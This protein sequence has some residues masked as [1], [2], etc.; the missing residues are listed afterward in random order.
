MIE[1]IDAHNRP[2]RP[3]SRASSTLLLPWPAVLLAASPSVDMVHLRDRAPVVSPQFSTCLR[4]APRPSQSGRRDH[5]VGSITAAP[6]MSLLPKAFGH[7]A[8]TFGGDCGV[9]VYNEA[10][11][12]SMAGHS[13]AWEASFQSP[14]APC[15]VAA[16]YT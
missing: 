9:A 14:T 11:K 1:P 15:R 8:C 7:V 10:R 3:M 12:A 5:G 6:S 16:V 13:A 2:T 4:S